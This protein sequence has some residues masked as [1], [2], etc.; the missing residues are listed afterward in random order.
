M[1]SARSAT[2][3]A[4]EI[5]NAVSDVCESWQDGIGVHGELVLR[6]EIAY[7]MWFQYLVL[8]TGYLKGEIILYNGFTQE[9]FQELLTLL[10]ENNFRSGLKN[11][12]EPECRKI[13]RK[14]GTS[15]DCFF[16]SIKTPV[17][18]GKN[19]AIKKIR[20]LIDLLKWFEGI[21]ADVSDEDQPVPAP[22]PSQVPTSIDFPPL[23]PPIQGPLVATSPAQPTLVQSPTLF[24]ATSTSWFEQASAPDSQLD[25]QVAELKKKLAALEKM[26]REQALAAEFAKRRE[27]ELAKLEAEFAERR[28]AI[29]AE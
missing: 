27:Q 20:E 21:N 10:Q 24:Q 15:I 5:A 1:S 6:G 19:E 29:L 14:D 17:L 12:T 28:A 23:S 11:I 18:K 22:V 13:Q 8:P 2:E 26:Q 25:E 3:I 9:G 4:T 7:K 16:I